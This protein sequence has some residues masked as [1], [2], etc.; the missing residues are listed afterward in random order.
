VTDLVLDI[1]GCLNLGSILLSGLLNFCL[2]AFYHFLSHG[3]DLGSSLLFFL[4]VFSDL[5]FMSFFIFNLNNQLTTAPRLLVITSYL[6]IAKGLYFQHHMHRQQ[7][8]SAGSKVSK[9]HFLI[10]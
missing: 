9:L 6:I 7:F 3:Y 10:V 2:A 1:I 5:S 4:N 8:A